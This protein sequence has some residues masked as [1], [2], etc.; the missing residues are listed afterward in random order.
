MRRFNYQALGRLK[1]GVMNATEL[2]YANYLEGLKRAGDVL[3]YK[4]EGVK[5][6]LA[7]NTFLSPD[8]VVIARDGQVEI[9]EVKGFMLDDANVKLKVAAETYPFIF[10]LI[11]KGKGGAWLIT[12]V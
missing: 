4:F 6:R 1:S 5:L 12:E 3:W 7:N 8:F 9:H 10:K 2:A 11:K